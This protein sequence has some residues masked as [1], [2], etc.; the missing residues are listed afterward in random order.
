MTSQTVTGTS[1]STAPVCLVGPLEPDVSQLLEVSAARPTFT[2]QTLTGASALM[3]PSCVVEPEPLSVSPNAAAAWFNRPIALSC[4]V[5]GALTSAS[6][7]GWSSPTEVVEQLVLA[8]AVTPTESEQALMGTFAL[9]TGADCRVVFEP[10]V[11]FWPGNEVLPS[12]FE[13]AVIGTPAEAGADGSG[14]DAGPGGDGSGLDAGPGAAGA[15]DP[16]A[17][18]TAAA[19]AFCTA[20]SVV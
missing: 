2:E 14:F 17:A 12:W 19:P 7:P 10:V 8:S 1:A 5:I 18:A 9:A 16:V 3:A 13:R 20:C 4:A 15:V 6:P 11:E